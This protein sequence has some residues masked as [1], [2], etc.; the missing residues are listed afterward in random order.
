MPETV[1]CPSMRVG[2]LVMVSESRRGFSAWVTINHESRQAG[3]CSLPGNPEKDWNVGTFTVPQE[4]QNSC[5]HDTSQGG[6]SRKDS[7]VTPSSPPE[8]AEQVCTGAR[9]HSQFL[10]TQRAV[11][12]SLGLPLGGL[13]RSCT[14]TVGRVWNTKKQRLSQ[15]VY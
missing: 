13:Q 1:E 7:R 14:T 8:A 5:T 2:K 15:N 10:G 12:W 3:D 6:G 11:T 4:R 9:N